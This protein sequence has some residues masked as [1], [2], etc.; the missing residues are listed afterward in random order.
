[1]HP[2]QQALNLYLRFRATHA[3]KCMRRIVVHL[4]YMRHGMQYNMATLVRI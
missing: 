3:N 1:M 2:I 4:S